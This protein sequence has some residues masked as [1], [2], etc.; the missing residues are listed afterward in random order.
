MC[1][2]NRDSSSVGAPPGASGGTAFNVRSLASH[3]TTVL[4]NDFIKQDRKVQELEANALCLP[5]ATNQRLQPTRFAPRG[6][7]VDSAPFRTTQKG[8]EYAFA[9]TPRARRR[10]D[11][12]YDL[13]ARDAFR[14]DC[15][16]RL[17]RAFSSQ[18]PHELEHNEFARVKRKEAQRNRG[19]GCNFEKS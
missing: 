3:S 4:L 11:L 5:C 13:Y 9:K 17:R 16:R 1:V 8:N 19:S 2:L 15:S 6:M 10:S 18:F 12:L 7:S 14:S